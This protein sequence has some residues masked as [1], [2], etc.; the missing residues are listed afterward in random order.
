VNGEVGALLKTMILLF[1]VLIAV[2]MEKK[3]KKNSKNSSIP[4]SQTHKDE[5]TPSQ[6]GSNGKGNKQNDNLFRNTRTVES[7]DIAKVVVVRSAAKTSAIHP[8]RG[9][10][11]AP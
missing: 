10:N 5:T 11:G 9:M 6:T 2:F 7:V 1:E 3:T 8:Q 4:P